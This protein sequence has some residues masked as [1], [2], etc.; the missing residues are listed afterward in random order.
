MVEEG[1][2]FAEIVDPQPSQD[3]ID[4]TV[5]RDEQAGE[6]CGRDQAGGGGEALPAS[7]PGSVPPGHDHGAG[8]GQAP[9]TITTTWPPLNAS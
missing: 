2:G 9:T 4:V 6:R 7:G 3:R 8:P 5:G 1:G